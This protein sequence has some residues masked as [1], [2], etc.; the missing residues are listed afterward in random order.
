[1]GRAPHD[2]RL[3]EALTATMLKVFPTV[4]AIDVPG[5]LNTILVA[6][7]EPTTAANLQT[8]LENLS[9]DV[10]PLLVEALQTAVDDLRRGNG[11]IIFL[12]G[13]AGLGKSRLIQ[14][15]KKTV[16]RSLDGIEWRDT[17]SYSYESQQPYALIHR[18]I[19][20]LAGLETTDSQQMFREKLRAL[21]DQ[22]MAGEDELGIQV[23]ESLFGLKSEVGDPLLCRRGVA[24]PD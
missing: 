17:F 10:D 23:L 7:V 2:R 9:P 24:Q 5:A 21:S 20:R 11:G 19:R 16:E 12:L 13:E 22:A 4:H 15:L 14:E 3:V 1:M 18:L 6:T 8:N